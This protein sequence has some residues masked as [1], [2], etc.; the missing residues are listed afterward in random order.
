[1]GSAAEDAARLRDL[2]DSCYNAVP[3]ETKDTEQGLMH[4]ATILL[5]SAT[6]LADASP[7]VVTNAR[8]IVDGRLYGREIRVVGRVRDAVRD[9][10]NDAYNFLIVDCGGSLLYGGLPSR[11]RLSALRAL[12]RFVGCEV[13]FTCRS[14]KCDQSDHRKA[15]MAELDEISPDG[16]RILRESAHDV[17]DAPPLEP[18]N[19]PL[20][21]ILTSGPRTAKGRVVARWDDD[22]MLVQTADGEAVT[23]K[24]NEPT[25]PALYETVEVVGAPNTD[26]YHYSLVQARW[27]PARAEAGPET[28]AVQPRCIGRLLHKNGHYMVSAYDHGKAIRLRGLVKERSRNDNG[29]LRLRLSD[30]RYSLSVDC[31]ALPQA[32][33][34]LE[35][36]STVVVTGVFVFLCDAWS[37]NNLFPKVRELLLVMRDEDSITVVSRPPWWTPFRC[38][39]A[40]LGLTALLLVVL[41]RARAAK[42]KAALKIGERTRLAAELHDN[43]AQ[44]L[45]VVS[46]RISAARNA[47]AA[48]LPVTG[49]HLA[50]AERMLQSCRTDLRRCLWDLRNDVLNEPDFASAIRQTILPIAEGVS[51]RVRFAVAR[52]KLS[53]STAHAILCIVRELVFNAVTHGKASEVRVAG[54]GE[55][56]TILFS[57]TDNGVGFDPERRPT[58]LEGHFGLD[59]V[60]ERIRRH[61]GGLAIE[62]RPGHG[63]RIVVTLH[64]EE[65]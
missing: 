4:I 22:T 53:D 18:G 65:R 40:I 55:A 32:F 33:D 54:T 5:L 10:T 39:L 56:D 21:A 52:A 47:C 7:P 14:R 20:E 12:Q 29:T 11:N 2:R 49:D 6:A 43:L 23:V 35:E 9:T 45:T 27:R 63:T 46:Y 37:P 41:A 50:H 13:T 38:F 26:L 3:F 42:A 57:V 64:N 19:P 8:Q 34:R 60:S 28:P 51:V 61:D 30:G 59:G 62:S 24:L 17:F 44:N 16:I 25:L 1:M 15:F 48:G 31:T 58:A 36:G